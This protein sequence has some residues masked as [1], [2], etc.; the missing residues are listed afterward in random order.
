VHWCAVWLLRVRVKTGDSGVKGLLLLVSRMINH[1]LLWV[2]HVLLHVL[3][4]VRWG[5]V[6]GQS[7]GRTPARSRLVVKVLCM[8]WRCPVGSTVGRGRTSW[9]VLMR[10]WRLLRV[11]LGVRHLTVEHH[12]GLPSDWCVKSVDPW[13]TAL[14]LLLLLLCSN[15][16]CLSLGGRRHGGHRAD[17]G[18]VILHLRGHLG[19]CSS[20]LRG[21]RGST[22]AA[23]RGRH[24]A[25]HGG[26][27][28]RH[29]GLRSRILLPLA[30]LLG[31]AVGTIISL[32]PTSIAAATAASRI[33]R[34]LR[35]LLLL[36]V[37]VLHLD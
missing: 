22:R 14:L 1:L 23:G 32:V 6:R 10:R 5:A 12:E 9:T 16:G 33:A 24:S 37:L 3:L 31:T 11:L 35:L 13:L 4:L 17:G 26:I 34:L 20:R 29:P 21:A 7:V 36:G 18:C 19:R 30:V 27:V 25:S 15:S 28:T 8:R 2:V